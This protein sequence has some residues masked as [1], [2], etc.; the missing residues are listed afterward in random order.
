[1]IRP[2]DRIIWQ[3]CQPESVKYDA[4]SYCLY[5]GEGSLDWS[6]FP[7]TLNRKYYIVIGRTPIYGHVKDYSFTSELEDIDTYVKQ[8]QVEWSAEGLTFIEKAGHR[9]FFPKEMFVGGR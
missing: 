5:V 6:R 7:Y 8:S 1:M 4:Y 9:L 3:S 2:S